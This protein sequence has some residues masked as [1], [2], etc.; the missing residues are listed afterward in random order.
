ML[1]KLK[2]NLPV[3]RKRYQAEIQKSAK[4]RFMYSGMVRNVMETIAKSDQNKI[5]KKKALGII[6]RH[7]MTSI[8]YLTDKDDNAKV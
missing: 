4:L 5:G 1:K 6:E 7:C 3:S 2:S 8:Q